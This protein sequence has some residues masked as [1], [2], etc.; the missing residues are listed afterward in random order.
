MTKCEFCGGE[1]KNVAVHQRFCKAK[2]EAVEAQAKIDVKIREDAEA[3]AKAESEETISTPESLQEEAEKAKIEQEVVSEAIAPT[4]L[5]EEKEDDNKISDEQIKIVEDTLNDD[6]SGIKIEI[7]SKKKGIKEEI[8]EETILP[9][10]DIAQY[11]NPKDIGIDSDVKIERIKDGLYI[12]DFNENKENWL[13]ILTKIFDNLKEGDKIVLELRLNI[14]HEF[15][16]LSY[17]YRYPGDVFLGLIREYTD[18]WKDGFNEQNKQV[19]TFFRT[20]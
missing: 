7:K 19:F 3:K 12:K 6:L 17:G 15:V 11:I 14:A 16:D 4:V 2:K 1:Y 13:P 5:K 18:E 9:E 10:V 20:K 8:K